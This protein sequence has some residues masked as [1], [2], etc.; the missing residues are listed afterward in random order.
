MACP[1]AKVERPKTN[2]LHPKATI[3]TEQI[4]FVLADLK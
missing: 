1:P 3:A 4:I 2:Y